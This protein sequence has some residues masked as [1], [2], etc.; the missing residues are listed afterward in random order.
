M[1]IAVAA[2]MQETNTFS[3]QRT[4]HADFTVARGDAVYGVQKW[5][6]RAV[7]GIL[8]TLAALGYTVAP[9]YC[10]IALPGV[11]V[12]SSGSVAGLDVASHDSL[13]GADSPGME[14]F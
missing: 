13:L 10:A 2:M 1:K 5:K 4:E 9:G 8:D 14:F 12:A 7:F 3:H 11:L 6:N